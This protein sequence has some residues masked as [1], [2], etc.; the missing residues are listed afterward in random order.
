[1]LLAHSASATLRKTR[2]GNKAKDRVGYPP[3]GEWLTR[4]NKKVL[5]EEKENAEL[6]QIKWNIQ[7]IKTKIGLIIF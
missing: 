6:S 4:Q 5:H 7:E 1:M 2:K 3:A